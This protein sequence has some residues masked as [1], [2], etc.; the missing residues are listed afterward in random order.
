MFPRGI[1]GEKKHARA[2]SDELLNQASHWQQEYEAAVHRSIA[3][4]AEVK[5]GMG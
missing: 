1:A 2:K 3:S 4:E 5:K